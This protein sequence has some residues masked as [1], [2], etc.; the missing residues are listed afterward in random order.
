MQMLLTN[1][2]QCPFT[3]NLPGESQPLLASISALKLRLF[4]GSEPM[5]DGTSLSPKLE[6]PTFR[7]SSGDLQTPQTQ[8]VQYELC[9]FPQNL[10]I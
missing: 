7:A 2:A 5:S 10:I 4:P 1:Q 6:L 9:I 8:Y 3:C